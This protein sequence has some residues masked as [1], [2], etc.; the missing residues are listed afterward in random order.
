MARPRTP[1]A[2]LELRGAFINHP[3]RLHERQNEPFVTE[4]L[5]DAP[6][7]I[8]KP[9]KIAWTEMK[10]RGSLWLRSPDQ[11]LVHIAAF[12]MAR[13]RNGECSSAETALLIKGLNM[14]GFSPSERRKLNLPTGS[15]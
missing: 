2:V 8:A 15:T 6:R 9:V 14:I 11:F 4:P 13:Y 5:P 7:G 3:S 12:Y 10:E 1:T